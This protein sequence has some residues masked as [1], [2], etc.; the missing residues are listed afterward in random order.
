MKAKQKIYEWEF[1]ISKISLIH[2]GLRKVD[3]RIGFTWGWD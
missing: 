1:W 2:I 3:F